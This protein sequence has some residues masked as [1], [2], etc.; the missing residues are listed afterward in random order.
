M[1]LTCRGTGVE[2]SHNPQRKDCEGMAKSER[3]YSQYQVQ[4]GVK[5]AIW[6]SNRSHGN[7]SND[8]KSNG[9]LCRISCPRIHEPHLWPMGLGTRLGPRMGPWH[10]PRPR[11]GPWH[12]LGPWPQLGLASLRGIPLSRLRGGGLSCMGRPGMGLSS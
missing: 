10:G 3:L 8:R 12:G 4:G 1:C 11:L 7:G 6:R 9:V 2:L 5:N